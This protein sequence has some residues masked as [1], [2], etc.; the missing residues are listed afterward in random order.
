[1]SES[2]LLEA[3]G[4]KQME[5]EDRAY[6]YT[7][8]IRLLAQVVSGEIA[9][10]RVIVNLTEQTWSYVAIGERPSM[11]P[12]I[13]GVPVC[14]VAPPDPIQDGIDALNARDAKEPG[15]ITLSLPG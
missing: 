9:R 7:S 15:E 1:M 13:N 12:Q 6:Q 4:R 3:L 14:I 10:S 5:L 11:P 2:Q 8:L